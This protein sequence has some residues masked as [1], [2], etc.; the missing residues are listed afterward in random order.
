MTMINRLTVVEG[1][2]EEFRRVVSDISA[3][4]RA[5][6]GFLGH[7]LHRSVNRPAVY[8]ETAQWRDAESHRSAMR[9]EGFRQNV[10]RLAGLASAEPDIFETLED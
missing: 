1:K 10:Q 2:E 7:R 8:V 6:P 9:G 3:Y 4:M 5:Q